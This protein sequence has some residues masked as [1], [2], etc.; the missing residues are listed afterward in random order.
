MATR[1][2]PTPEELRQLLRYDP[3]SGKLYWLPRP[4][5]MFANEPQIT[6]EARCRAWNTSW[7][8]KEAFTASRDLGYKVGAIFGTNFRAHRVA[9]A[10]YYGEWPQGEIDHIDGDPSNNQIANLRVTDRTGNSRNLKR[11]AT[12]T[13]GCGGVSYDERRGLWKA[14]IWV[15]G[16]QKFLGRFKHK[17][18]AVLARLLAERERGYSMRHGVA[19]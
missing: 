10:I 9:W 17:F 2:L 6:P 4:V 14:Y 1:I 11:N 18:D 13:S 19:A 5:E 15:D 16:K 12:N 3:E 7:A 8:N